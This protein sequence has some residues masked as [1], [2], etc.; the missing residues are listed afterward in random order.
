ML[1]EVDVMHA[2]VVFLE[3]QI[4]SCSKSLTVIPASI[5]LQVLCQILI[6]GRNLN[7]E[8]VFFFQSLTV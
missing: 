4:T 2:G 8:T 3:Q 6:L 5:G 1:L 7:T